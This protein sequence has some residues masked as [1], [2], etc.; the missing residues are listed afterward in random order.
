MEAA[1]N[2]S[3]KHALDSAI[4]ADFDVFECHSRI[5]TVLYSEKNALER[6]CLLGCS[7][8]GEAWPILKSF[9]LKGHVTEYYWFG[10]C[11][12]L[13]SYP[14]NQIISETSHVLHA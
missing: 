13:K 5:A 7:A 9:L 6:Y 10:Y 2:A 11:L 3:Q 12:V 8:P 4:L 1:G 14:S